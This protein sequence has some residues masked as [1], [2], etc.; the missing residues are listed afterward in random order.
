MRII[1]T[2]IK[3]GIIT[4]LVQEARKPHNQD[5]LRRLWNQATN[6]AQPGTTR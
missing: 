2:A 6:K 3:A 1:R 4:K 5:K